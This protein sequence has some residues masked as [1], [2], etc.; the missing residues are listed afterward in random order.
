MARSPRQAVEEGTLSVHH[1]ADIVVCLPTVSSRAAAL[2]VTLAQWRR[3]GVTPL[4]ERQPDDWPLGSAPQRRTAER[5]VRCALDA[6]PD[7][8][9]VL[10]TEDDVDL[11]LELTTWLPTLLLLDAPVTLFVNG[12]QY[13]PAHIQA[14]INARLPLDEGVVQIRA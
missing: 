13:Y 10:F 9:H 2:S 3:L 6:R 4:V 11:S 5:A 7:A 12:T 14:Q 1:V 8:S